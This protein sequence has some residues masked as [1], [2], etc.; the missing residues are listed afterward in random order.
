MAYT[1]IESHKVP[2]SLA[3]YDTV[4]AVNDETVV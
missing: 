2:A 4:V 3:A 1:G